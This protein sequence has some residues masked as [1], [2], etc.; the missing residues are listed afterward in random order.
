MTKSREPSILRAEADQTVAA[1]S[2]SF[3]GDGRRG[4]KSGLHRA[5]CQVTPG[6][7]NPRPVQQRANRRWPTQVGSGKGE[8]VR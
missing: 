4:G 7:G 2:S 1:S 3:R 8:R 6:G 5:G